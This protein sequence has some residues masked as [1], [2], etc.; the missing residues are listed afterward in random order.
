MPGAAGLFDYEERTEGEVDGAPFAYADAVRL[1]C[2]EAVEVL[3][4]L[5]TVGLELVEDHS[6]ELFGTA[7]RY[8]RVGRS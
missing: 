1:R 3:P 5:A 6:E 2:W 4:I 7:S 8:L